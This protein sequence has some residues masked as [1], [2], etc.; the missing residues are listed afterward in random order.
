VCTA[1]QH[2]RLNSWPKRAKRF[3][4]RTVSHTMQ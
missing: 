4:A 3:G 2:T 1:E